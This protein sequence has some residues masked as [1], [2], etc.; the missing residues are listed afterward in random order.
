MTR[1]RRGISAIV[2]TGLVMAAAGCGSG[3]DRAGQGSSAAKGGVVKVATDAT[4]PPFEYVGADNRTMEGFDIDLGNALAKQL[5]AQVQFSQLSFDGLIPALRG[6][7][8]D[9][10]MAAMADLPA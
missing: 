8:F 6:G 9:L 2:A 4:F 7:R 3:E 1:M 5:G 10:I